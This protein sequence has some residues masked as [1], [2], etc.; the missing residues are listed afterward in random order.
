M[1]GGA[2]VRKRGSRKWIK[3]TSLEVV[4]DRSTSSKVKSNRKKDAER[5]KLM[6]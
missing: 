6:D 4:E 3:E 5:K 1:K 2:G